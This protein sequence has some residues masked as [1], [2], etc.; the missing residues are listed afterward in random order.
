MRIDALKD[1][2]SENKLS[3][4]KEYFEATLKWILHD[5]DERKNHLKDLISYIHLSTLTPDYLMSYLIKTIP[6]KHGYI[7]FD[8]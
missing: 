3:Y 6:H 5:A 1:I 2:L 7:K 4:E 8:Q